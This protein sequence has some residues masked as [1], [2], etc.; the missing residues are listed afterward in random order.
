MLDNNKNAADKNTHQA[1]KGL[2]AKHGRKEGNTLKGQREIQTKKRE[3]IVQTITIVSLLHL[4]IR[5]HKTQKDVSK[6]L[7]VEHAR[8]Q[9]PTSCLLLVVRN[10]VDLKG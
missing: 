3:Q 4:Q 5:K 8:T 6:I 2:K 10:S 9:T 1:A 7:N